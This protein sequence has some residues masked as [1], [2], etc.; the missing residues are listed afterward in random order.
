MTLFLLS[1]DNRIARRTTMSLAVH[2]PASVL[3]LR[4]F[5][6]GQGLQ[7]LGR[8]LRDI[9]VTV[10]PGLNSTLSKVRDRTSE[11]VS[12]TMMLR[13]VS[14]FLLGNVATMS[15]GLSL[16]SS[17]ASKTGKASLMIESLS[18]LARIL[19]EI[20]AKY[21]SRVLFL[22]AILLRKRLAK[23]GAFPAV[24]VSGLLFLINPLSSLV[25]LL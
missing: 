12:H 11:M 19:C 3:T 21:L 15:C 4:L 22:I 16:A 1:S 13:G 17:S 6:T 24:K 5:A 10:D 7:C 9:K 23:G 2:D 8:H 18:D 25:L 20:E 14:L